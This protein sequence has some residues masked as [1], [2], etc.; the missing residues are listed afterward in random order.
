VN[1]WVRSTLIEAK[2]RGKSEMGGK[3][4][5]GVTGKGTSFEM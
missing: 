4:G 5:G 3:V 1:E 2:G